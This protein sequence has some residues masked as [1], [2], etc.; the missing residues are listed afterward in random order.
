MKALCGKATHSSSF[1]S[2]L[3]EDMPLCK[4]GPSQSTQGQ[5]TSEREDGDGTHP[6]QASLKDGTVTA[7]P[8]Y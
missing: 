5:G 2:G 4:L 6:V 8:F 7:D 3:R 1:L